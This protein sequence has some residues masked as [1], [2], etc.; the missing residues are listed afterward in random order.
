MK[1]S[2]SALTR[3]RLSALAAS[4]LLAAPAAFAQTGA[5][6]ATA[7]SMPMTSEQQAMMQTMEK[8]NRDMMAGMHV[9]GPDQSFAAMLLPHHQGAVEMAQAY[10]KG[11]KDPELRRMAEKTVTDQEKDILELREWQA[12]H[13]P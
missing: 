3:L 10:L 9:P 13:R 6:T 12:K 7:Q 4:M 5:A 1:T 8:M 2:F 11:G